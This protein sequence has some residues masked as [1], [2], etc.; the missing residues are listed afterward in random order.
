MV[1]RTVSVS[2]NEVVV[3]LLTLSLYSLRIFEGGLWPTLR[4][5]HLTFHLLS[6]VQSL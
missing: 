4:C 3:D 5:S 2:S 6:V 1:E